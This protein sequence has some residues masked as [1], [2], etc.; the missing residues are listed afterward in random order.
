MS[1]PILALPEG[2]KQSPV[3]VL[4]WQNSVQLFRSNGNWC[5]QHGA[6]DGSIIPIVELLKEIDEMG[7]K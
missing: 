4:S 1:G 3:Q 7:Q 6:A 5:V 2:S